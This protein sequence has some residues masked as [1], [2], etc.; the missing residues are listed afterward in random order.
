MH[1]DANSSSVPLSLILSNILTMKI[2]TD[3]ISCLINSSNSFAINFWQ[4]L[5]D[6]IIWAKQWHSL[7]KRGN[8]IEELH[9]TWCSQQRVYRAVG[10]RMQ[11]STEVWMWSEKT[12]EIHHK[13]RCCSLRYVQCVNCTDLIDSDD[14]SQSPLAKITHTIPL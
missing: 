14:H 11:V 6:H 13:R 8:Y 7:G 5:L 3:T 1:E 2:Q 12:K 9:W 10:N 4:S